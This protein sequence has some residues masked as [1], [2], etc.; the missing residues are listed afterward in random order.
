[1]YP[2]GQENRNKLFLSIHSFI[3]LITIPKKVNIMLLSGLLS[4]H[5]TALGRQIKNGVK[6]IHTSIHDITHVPILCPH[7]YPLMH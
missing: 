5:P 6:A 7:S 3:L 4:S 1:M 2:T